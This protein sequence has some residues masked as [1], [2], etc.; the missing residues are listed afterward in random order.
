MIRKIDKIE[1]MAVF[2][3]FDWDTS[4]KENYGS[5]VEFQRV[6][7]IY[8]RNYSGKTTLSRIIRAFETLVSSLK[9]NRK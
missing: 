4:V 8:G 1:N 7:V 3:D 2:K 6:N 5:I 9:D